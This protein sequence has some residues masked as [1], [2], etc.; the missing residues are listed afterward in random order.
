MT[1]K[2]SELYRLAAKSWVE[3]DNA[4]RMLEECKSAF[5][6]QRM[7][8]KGD[9][10]VSRAELEAKASDVW[11]GYIESMV[12]ARTEANLARVKLKWIEMRFSEQMSHEAT[13]RS[14][15]KL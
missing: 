1:E 15:R 14:E 6:S 9:M 12:K 4:A 13:E 3:L 11:T 7:L 10:P 5:L 2:L 8:E